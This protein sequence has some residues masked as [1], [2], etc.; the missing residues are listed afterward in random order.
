MFEKENAIRSAQHGVSQT[1]IRVDSPRHVLP[2]TSIETLGGSFRVSCCCCSKCKQQGGTGRSFFLRICSAFRTPLAPCSSHFSADGIPIVLVIRSNGL[3]QLLPTQRVAPK[4]RILTKTLHQ[5]RHTL[6]FCGAFH[7]QL[8]ESS[9]SESAQVRWFFF[10][11]RMMLTSL[12]T[13]C[14]RIRCSLRHVK[15]IVTGVSQRMCCAPAA[16]PI[17]EACAFALASLGSEV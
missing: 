16:F 5:E 17:A 15:T 9:P 8:T 13:L 6:G 4:T 1:G 11:F 12:D 2:K 10:F 3:C 7:G 14:I